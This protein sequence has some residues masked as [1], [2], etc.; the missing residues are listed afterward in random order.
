MVSVSRIT[1]RGRVTIPKEIREEASLSQG[2][3]VAFEVDGGGLVA[4]RLA[5]GRDSYSPG[6]SGTLDEWSSTEDEDAWRDL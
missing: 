2:D 3:V 4:Y 1:T 6:L 5:D